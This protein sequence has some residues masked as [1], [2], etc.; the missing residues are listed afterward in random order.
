M[1]LSL[2]LSARIIA[3]LLASAAFGSLLLSAEERHDHDKAV[4]PAATGKFAP[5]DDKTDATWLAKARAAYPLETCVVSEEKLGG[6]GKPPE[7]VYQQA[8]QPDRL[9][10]FC[11][12]SCVADF[13]KEPAKYLTVIDAAAAKAAAKK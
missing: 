9:V 6:M 10:R 8:G 7:Y 13:A 12:K 3:A 5:V 1:K 4:A 11:C 2:S